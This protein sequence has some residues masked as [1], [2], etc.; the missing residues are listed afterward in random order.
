MKNELQKPRRVAEGSCLIIC[1]VF[2]HTNL[3]ITHLH[4][5]SVLRAE[6]GVCKQSGGNT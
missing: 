6:G 1:T 3:E 5:H 4:L 2:I